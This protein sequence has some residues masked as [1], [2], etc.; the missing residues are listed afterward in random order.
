MCRVQI[1]MQ[2]LAREYNIPYGYAVKTRRC[3]VHLRKR[4]GCILQSRVFANPASKGQTIRFR[5]NI[6]LQRPCEPLGFHLSCS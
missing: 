4:T 1:F 2:F 6:S 5:V 3:F